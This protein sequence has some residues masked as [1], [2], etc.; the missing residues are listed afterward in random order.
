ME[1]RG[2]TPPPQT[3]PR[4]GLKAGAS[5]DD[6]EAGGPLLEDPAAAGGSGRCWRIRPMLGWMADRVAAVS[7]LQ[8]ER[9]LLPPEHEVGAA[10]ERL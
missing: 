4:Q 2:A 1:V 5:W 3:W 9:L 8:D 7:D 6:L 10:V